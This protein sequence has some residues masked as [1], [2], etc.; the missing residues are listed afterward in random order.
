MP[1]RASTDSTPVQLLPIMM[2]GP[3]APALGEWH[4][5]G[6]CAGEDAEA[7]FPSHGDPGNG[8]RRVCAACSVRDECLSYATAADELGIWG[9]LDQQERRNLSRRQRRRRHA[10]VPAGSG[11]PGR[12]A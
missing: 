3:S 5:R 10:A 4:C 8:A 9:G 6:L 11:Q 12:T 1:E 7:F 2:P